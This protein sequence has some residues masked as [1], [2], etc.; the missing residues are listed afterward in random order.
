[1]SQN[2]PD[3]SNLTRRERQIMDI[4]YRQGKATAVEVMDSLPGKAVNATVRTMLNVLESKG[5]L[6]HE[7]IKGRFLY[8]PTISVAKARKTALENVLDTFFKGAEAN[9]VISILK[10]TESN[11]SNEDRERIADLIEKS[12]AEGR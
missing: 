10:Q 6:Y 4:I 8:Y 7:R 9:A 2:K 3:I 11:L 5:Y 12:R 1:M